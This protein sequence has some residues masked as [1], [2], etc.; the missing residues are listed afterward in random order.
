[1]TLTIF[2][3][4]FAAYLMAAGICLQIRNLRLRAVIFAAINLIGLRHLWQWPGEPAEANRFLL[5]YVLWV[6]IQYAFLRIFALRK[7]LL[8]WMAVLLPVASLVLFK[9]IDPSRH[10]LV[11]RMLP[12]LLGVSYMAFRLS[13]LVLEVRNE[14]IACPTL[15]EYL[16]FAFFV[17]TLAVGPISPFSRFHASFVAP[18]HSLKQLATSA[19]RIIV[20]ASKYFLFANL[21][22]R[23]AY[24]GLFNDGHPHPAVDV[25]IA[26]IAYYLYLYCNF[27]G[28]CDM[29]IGA[30]GVLGIDVAENF[31]SPLKSRNVKDFWNRWH[32]TLSSYMRDM[33]FTPLSKALITVCGPK[34]ANHAIAIAIGTVFLLVGLWHGFEWHYFLFGAAHAAGVVGNHYYTVYLKRFLGKQRFKA[35]TESRLIRAL[36]IGATFLYVSGTFFLFA[37]NSQATRGILNAIR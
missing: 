2:L 6:A 18:N 14:I 36:A 26:S 23:L 9:G 12:Y 16:A 32:I 17:P 31:E 27:S 22:N 35:Y 20:G 19:F 5:Y 1:M 21:A 15:S 3:P 7:S 24:A 34:S 11:P 33:V 25:V 4:R 13:H 37:N 10:W 28:F 29:A 30:A 8:P